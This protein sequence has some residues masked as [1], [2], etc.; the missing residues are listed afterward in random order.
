M[1]AKNETPRTSS[2]AGLNN[3]DDPLTIGLE[4]QV[5]AD[6][7]DITGAGKMVR[8]T[9]HRLAL[10]A[11][12]CTGAYGTK[13]L[14]HLYM[15]DAGTLY[16]VFPPSMTKVALRSGLSSGDMFFE[17][18]NGVVFF[19]N[20]T[21]YGLINGQGAQPWGIPNPDT[22]T[23]T[24]GNGGSM[25]AGVYQVVCTLV[26][27]LG[28]ES[29][30]SGVAVATLTADDGRIQITNIPQVTG[31]TTNVYVTE[32]DD[33]VFYLLQ[34]DAGVS[35][36]YFD[37][38]NLGRELPFWNQAPPRGSQPAFFAGRLYLAEYFPEADAT[39]VWRSLP[40]HYHHYDAGG[41]GIM[42]PGQVVQMGSSIE[43][44]FTG[45]ERL[46][47]RGV[48]DALIICTDREIHS[49]DED[50]LVKLASYGSVPGH[51]MAPV[52]GKVYF[53]TKRGLCRALP[54]ENLTES[55]V[56][57]PPGLSAGASVIE[58][59]GTRRYVVALHKGG[60]AYNPYQP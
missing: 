47:Q 27:S 46:T 41:E 38:Q 26:D 45:N 10:T 30:N 53:W 54:F 23:L 1:R 6:N 43:T 8:A 32:R 22:P 33:A 25:L 3:V 19:T 35:L 51:H 58:K 55:T 40:L 60:D 36:T 20:G 37:H 29:S 24:I 52:H 57:V 13:D 56:S 14:R 2:F 4:H 17:E 48:A 59:D 49:W 21:D 16:E 5:Q 39:A 11:S 12:S 31:Y 7:V 28:L 50:Q 34:E 18:V 9:G 42:V 44:H 15:V